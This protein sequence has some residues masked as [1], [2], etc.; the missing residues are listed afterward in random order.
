MRRRDREITDM[1]EMRYVLDACKVIHV[2][3]H[4]Q[5]DIYILPMN[6]GYTLEEGQLTFYLHGGMQGKKLDLIRKCSN[7]AFEMDCD[8]QLIEGRIACQY[9]YGYASIM[10]KGTIEIVEDPQ[11][12]IKAL[13]NLMECQTGKG[14]EFNE[15]L[16]SIVTVMKFTVSE[17]TGKRRPTGKDKVM[18]P[19]IKGIQTLTV[20]KENTAKAMGSGQMDVLATPAMVALMEQTAWMSVE[21]YMEEGCQ[22]VGT[23]LQ[24]KHSAPT[25][26]G[27]TVT[28]ESELTE[29]DKRRLVFHV[30][31]SD[32]EK[33][34]GEGEHE[35]FIVNTEKFMEKAAGK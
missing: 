14:F 8:H 26:I 24:I 28:C 15:R 22:T 5:D 10:G 1:E 35:R 2:G 34:I 18:K 32:G 17:F 11:E 27:G 4:D 19:G 16:V 29:V 30:T 31:V 25:V 33:I 20:T 12:K 3:L 23:M 9:G 7:A 13:T 21:E 6:Y